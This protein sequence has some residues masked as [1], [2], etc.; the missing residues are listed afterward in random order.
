MGEKSK[1]FK[2]FLDRLDHYRTL[3]HKHIGTLE[4]RDN[5]HC[6]FFNDAVQEVKRNEDIKINLNPI[7]YL[8]WESSIKQIVFNNGIC[9]T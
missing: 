3:P 5:E 9:V 6:V 1:K 7:E 2:A 8:G 4:D